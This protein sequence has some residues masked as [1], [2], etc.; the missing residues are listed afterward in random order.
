MSIEGLSFEKAWPNRTMGELFGRVNV[1]FIG[2]PELI[3]NKRAVGR[4]I[5]QHDAELLEG[6]G[7]SYE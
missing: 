2:K 4:P 3:R 5:D 1:P 7:S 6:A